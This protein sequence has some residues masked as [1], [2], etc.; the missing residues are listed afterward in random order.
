MSA[1]TYIPDRLIISGWQPAERTWLWV[2]TLIL[3]VA[4]A[5]RLIALPDNPPGLAQ[6]EVLDADI[7]QFIR[8]GEHAI[9]FSHGYGHEP[10][11][12]YWAVP[13]QVLFGDNIF[14]VRLPSVFLGLLLVAV[15]MRWAKRDF[16]GVVAL[17][18]GMGLAIS[19]WPII[20][21]RIGIRPILE[22]VLL[23]IAV[24]FWPTNGRP[25]SP[26]SIQRAG[27]A[28]LFLGLAIYSYTA[29]RVVLLL[30][31]L[32]L[33]YL[34][35]TYVI[36]NWKNNHSE[37]PKYIVRAQL[38]LTTIVFLA[39]LAVYLPLGLT[40]RAN[41]DLQQ[42]IQQLQG[43][44]IALQAGDPDPVIRATVAT[45]GVFA[46]TGDPRWTYSLPDRPLFDPLTALLFYAGLIVAFVRWRQ[47][48]FALLPLWLVV[49]LMPSAL[50]PD[51]PSTVR[52]V[53]AMPVTYVLTGIAMA[54]LLSWISG[55]KTLKLRPLPGGRPVIVVVTLVTIL[56]VNVYRTID[57]GFVSW[58]A[59]IETRTR[60]QAVIQDIGR[61]W[62]ENGKPLGPPVI[63]EV[64]FE[65]IDEASL[66]RT[67]GQ[68]PSA[69]WVQT[70]AGAPGAII[71]PSGVATPQ[72]YVPEFAP[73][74]PE[75]MLLAEVP[76]QPIFRS[77]GRPSFAIYELA[78]EP[79][80]P[81][82]VLGGDFGLA[83][84]MPLLTLQG[85]SEPK[86]LSGAGNAS[87]EIGLATFW[88]IREDLP[89]DLAV[90][91]H[92]ID[93]HGLIVGQSDGLDA[94][95]STLR[96]GDRLMQVHSIQ[97]DEK[98][99]G[100]SYRLITGLY[101]R[102]SGARLARSDGSDHLLLFDCENVGSNSTLDLVCSLPDDD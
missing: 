16:G 69:R 63:A 3:L 50:S 56:G 23:V 43:P 34:A 87:D 70:G 102:H 84:S 38:I 19:W 26:V 85:I 17:V 14:S 96:V 22:P 62:V 1:E 41:P 25:L 2:A 28:G 35:L 4:A 20:F 66:R 67:I 81:I 48:E 65:P 51:A 60:Y 11:Y 97:I 78:V 75:L 33:G 98:L 76:T 9:F 83:E 5:F 31:L 93:E 95:A 39:G 72:M 29:A 68:D 47:P 71:W 18:A 91:I 99:P 7:A 8:Q 6:D 54:A 82:R 77:S 73:L 52:L 74:S 64:F 30:P 37:T 89:A 101:L 49:T 21:S 12:H 27:L 100:G 42:R 24:W 86:M 15:T 53:G 94:V 10:L 92:L 79:K 40:L 46:L 88:L 32:F 55:M 36:D 57:D 90:F 13:F 80:I 44:L 58:P 59:D 61:H 45:L